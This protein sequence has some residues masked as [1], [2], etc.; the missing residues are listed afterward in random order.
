M[1]DPN[2]FDLR[3]A[4]LY[5]KG[6]YVWGDIG[7][8]L[9]RIVKDVYEKITTLR[10]VI[11]ALSPVI[12]GA[13]Q[14][15]KVENAIPGKPPHGPLYA[16][17]EQWL[18]LLSMREKFEVSWSAHPEFYKLT[19]EEV[20]A[21]EQMFQEEFNRRVLQAF[22]VPLAWWRPTIDLGDPSSKIGTVV[23]PPKKGKDNE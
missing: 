10:G 4:V 16:Y 5:A 1:T 18:F 21:L 19:P 14:E 11:I 15:Y 6:H 8:D 17:Q 3:H 7:K 20:K 22:L 13:I 2:E 12:W 23:S 9:L